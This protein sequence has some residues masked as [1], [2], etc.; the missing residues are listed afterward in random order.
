MTETSAQTSDPGASPS[1]RRISKIA[2]RVWIVLV[3]VLFLSGAVVPLATDSLSF[4]FY[5][6]QWIALAVGLN[7]AAGMIGYLPFGYVAFFGSGAYATGI[8][9]QIY[10]APLWVGIVGAA[11][12]GALV[13]LLFAPTLRLR[14]IFFSIVSMSL[15]IVMQHL[16][17]LLPSEF[18]GGSAGI[19]FAREQ[20]PQLYYYCM[21]VVAMLAVLAMTVLVLSRQGLMLKAIR[22][23][24][25][26]ARVIGLNVSAWRLAAWIGAA[27][28]AALCGS[29]EGLYSSIIDPHASFNILISAKAVIYAAIG[30]FGTVMGPVLGA[31]GMSVIDEIVWSRFPIANLFVLGA[32]VAVV[33]LYMPRGVVG[34]MLK[35]SPR[36]RRWLF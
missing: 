11:L 10:A 22:D 26:V 1:R 3:G 29:L 19:T 36:F 33:T 7:L 28:I 15:A 35:K 32:I 34:A 17:S 31:V 30:G 24:P 12:V 20:R 8:L 16:V 18:A 4:W 5:M 25:D 6:F 23:D 13:S 27:V 14:G 9:V 2:I 21:V